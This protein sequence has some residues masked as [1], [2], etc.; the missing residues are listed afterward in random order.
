MQNASMRDSNS[1]DDPTH[2]PGDE[3][4][5][6]LDESSVPP[7]SGPVVP[8]SD[9]MEYLGSYSSIPGYLR[10]MLEPEVTP[11]CAW[12]LDHLD[13]IAVQRRWESDGSRL[14]LEHGH[15]YRVTGRGP[16]PG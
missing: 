9:E 8:S 15:V 5:V 10:A 1:P 14:V 3:I 12:I 6:D 7:T 2:D 16:G 13:Y 11:A 4:D